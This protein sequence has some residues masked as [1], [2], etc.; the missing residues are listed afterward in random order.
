MIQS[1][2]KPKKNI[3]IPLYLQVSE[4]TE[5]SNGRNSRTKKRKFAKLFESI[6]LVREH[7][8][9]EKLHAPFDKMILR[10]F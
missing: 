10:Q 8:I 5:V 3:K 2:A 6:G 1:Q 7:F 9:N 4:S